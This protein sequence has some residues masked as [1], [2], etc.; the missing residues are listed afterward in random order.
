MKITSSDASLFLFNRQLCTVAE[1]YA[2]FNILLKSSIMFLPLFPI[3]SKTFIVRPL[4]DKTRLESSSVEF[5]KFIDKLRQIIDNFRNGI[6]LK[7]D[8][9]SYEQFLFQSLITYFTFPRSYSQISAEFVLSNEILKKLGYKCS[10]ENLILLMKEVGIFLENENM[11][12][13]FKGSSIIDLN[14]SLINNVGQNLH[15]ISNQ[16]ADKYLTD[17][18]DS[19]NENNDIKN[20]LTKLLSD[21]E[22]SFITPTNP[23]DYISDPHLKMR[24]DFGDLPVYVIDSASAHELDDG[25]SFEKTPKGSWIHIHIADPTSKISC[26][27][28]LATL[29]QIRASSVYLPEGAFRMLPISRLGLRGSKDVLTFSARIVN[30]IMEEYKVRIG[31]VNNVKIVTYDDVDILLNSDDAVKP[32]FT[33]IFNNSDLSTLENILDIAKCHLKTRI[34]NSAFFFNENFNVEIKTEAVELTSPFT[35]SFSTA[36]HFN[37]VK[38]NV[39]LPRKKSKSQLIVSE[40]MVIAGRIAS[41]YCQEVQIPVPYRSQASIEESNNN[42]NDDYKSIYKDAMSS[43]DEYGRVSLLNS[44]RLLP[45]I[46]SANTSLSPG[47]HFAMGINGSQSS[48]EDFGGY[49]R[50]TSPLRRYTDMLTH[51]Q[52]KSTFLNL[53]TP[54]S[55]ADVAHLCNSTS[56]KERQIKQMERKSIKFWKLE[57]IRRCELGSIAGEPVCFSAKNFVID[58]SV[59]TRIT[60]V[61]YDAI[62]IGENEKF[63]KVFVPIL[64]LDSVCLSDTMLEFGDSIKVR[65]Q[66]VRPDNLKVMFKRI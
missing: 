23:H 26:L 61:I 3:S 47:R 49:V 40:M 9:T 55:I 2:A 12:K 7:I 15:L 4:V 8:F 42:Y 30:G 37:N 53:K 36:N 46:S 62:V 1:E 60:D 5:E 25:I 33:N 18:N 64:G 16:C 38:I 24:K 19:N 20:E 59:D 65:V 6:K 54:F 58:Y 28:P 29:S 57:Y 13:Y 22:I 44:F 56:E 14:C 45:F 11:G 52:I 31:L 51:Y 66:S 34:E 39:E 43:R 50:A 27:N 48:P 17:S 10:D 41:K 35:K 21:H 32:G 63:V